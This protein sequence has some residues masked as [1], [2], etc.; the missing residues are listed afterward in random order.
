MLLLTVLMSSCGQPPSSFFARFT[1]NRSRI[2][3]ERSQSVH[4][5]KSEVEV[6]E[7]EDPTVTAIANPG[8]K[9]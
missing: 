5:T 4:P 2:G 9:I 6:V 3:G 8:L 7:V 1:F